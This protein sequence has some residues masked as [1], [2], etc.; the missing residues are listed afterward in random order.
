MNNA[1]IQFC[2]STFSFFVSL[3]KN[4]LQMFSIL[5]SQTSAR[6]S[7]E[8][9]AQEKKTANCDLA[10]SRSGVKVRLSSSLCSWKFRESFLKPYGVQYRR[11]QGF[12]CCWACWLSVL[13]I[14]IVFPVFLSVN[15]GNLVPGKKDFDL[16]VCICVCVFFPPFLSFNIFLIFCTA[17]GERSQP[18]L[19]N[20]V[21]PAYVRVCVCAPAHVCAWLRC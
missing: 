13:C 21:L 1:R 16:Y 19:R 4:S 7:E 18:S 15:L 9:W 8:C 14:I 5:F 11:L 20:T 10:M 17:G 2:F 3:G 6:I 12:E